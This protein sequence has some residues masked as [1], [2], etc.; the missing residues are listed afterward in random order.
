MNDTLEQCFNEAIG[1]E[2]LVF[3][4]GH[5]QAYL[6]CILYVVKDFRTQAVWN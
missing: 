6:E 3:E 4:V 1:Q 2:D 5:L